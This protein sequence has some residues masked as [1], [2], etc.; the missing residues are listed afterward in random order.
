MLAYVGLLLVALAAGE[1]A[2]SVATGFLPVSSTS[3]RILYIVTS[4][5][6][7]TITPQALTFKGFVVSP[8]HCSRCA[9]S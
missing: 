6:K 2:A 3:W 8:G 7:H 1:P 9:A 5:F 4:T